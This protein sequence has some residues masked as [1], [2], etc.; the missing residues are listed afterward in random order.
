MWNQEK[1][2]NKVEGDGLTYI[3]V[4]REERVQRKIDQFLEM[5]FSMP[6]GFCANRWTGAVQWDEGN[7]VRGY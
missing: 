1:S 6:I 2:R 7:H 3:V 4:A 5:P